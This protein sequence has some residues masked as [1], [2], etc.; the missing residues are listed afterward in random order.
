MKADIGASAASSTLCSLPPSEAAQHPWRYTKTAHRRRP[1]PVVGQV[2]KMLRLLPALRSFA[3]SA[4]HRLYL[5]HTS[6]DFAAVCSL[7][8]N[9]WLRG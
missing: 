1:K 8:T 7:E 4:N 5:I 6:R 9:A 3:A 2:I